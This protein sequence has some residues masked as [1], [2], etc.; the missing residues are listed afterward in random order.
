MKIISPRDFVD[1]VLVRT[2]EDG[3]ISSNGEWQPAAAEAPGPRGRSALHL[4]PHPHPQGSRPPPTPV[5]V[6]LALS[7]P[8]ALWVV[9]GE[10]T[11]PRLVTSKA[12]GGQRP[13][14]PC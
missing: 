10:G 11:V 1:L 3:T 2:Y 4:H 12:Q 9:L 13:F 14:C 8:G 6:P 7:G 5:S